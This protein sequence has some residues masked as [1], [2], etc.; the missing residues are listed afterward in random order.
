MPVLTLDD[1]SPSFLLRNHHINTVYPFLF[2]SSSKLNYTREKFNT[3]DD[4]FIHLDY[5]RSGNKKIP[6]ICHG[7]EGSSN[8]QYI[9]H[10]AKLLFENE[11]DVCC[12]N[13]RSCSGVMN[14]NLQMYHSGFTD[15]VHEVIE[16]LTD[17]Y[18]SI[19][20]IGFAILTLNVT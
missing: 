16:T 7:L 19:S 6:V 15:D 11:W 5:L 10:T 12:I 20:L 4:D 8:S 14:K 3:S 2:R 9:I 13:F 1:Y 17:K 18:S